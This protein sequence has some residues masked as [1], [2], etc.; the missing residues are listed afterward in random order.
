MPLFS[1]PGRW[2]DVANPKKLASDSRNGKYLLTCVLTS[3][4][5]QRLYVVHVCQRAELESVQ[6]LAFRLKLLNFRRHDYPK[7]TLL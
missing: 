2:P 7:G 3:P 1:P 6:S 5:S 4:G